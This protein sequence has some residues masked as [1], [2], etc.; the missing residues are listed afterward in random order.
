[1]TETPK[2]DP[3]RSAAIRHL[4]I[5]N[6]EAEPKRR[7]SHLRALLAGL[8]ITGVVASGSTAL[9]LN[10][11]SLFGAPAPSTGVEV[12]TPPTPTASVTTPPAQETES[13]ARISVATAP[14]VPQDIATQPTGPTWSLQPPGLGEPGKLVGSIDISEDYALISVAPE[15]GADLTSESLPASTSSLSVTLVNTRT[16]D[17]V[18]SRE[19]HW[20]LEAGVSSADARALV[21]GTSGRVLVVTT[22]SENGPREV[23]DLSTGTAVAAFQPAEPGETLKKV[24]VV[25]GDS[26]DVYATLAQRD[27][28]GDV[29]PYSLVKRFDPANT[30]DAQWVTRIDA[31]GVNV[32]DS[33]NDIGYAKVTYYAGDPQQ[34]GNGVLDLATGAFV[35]RPEPFEY[36]PF[37]GYTIRSNPD[38]AGGSSTL[39]GLDDDGNTLWT[40]TETGLAQ[41]DEVLTSAAIPGSPRWSTVGTGQFVVVSANGVALVDGLTGSTIWQAALADWKLEYPSV[42]L[43][44]EAQGDVLTVTNFGGSPSS[45]VDLT[46]GAWMGFSPWDISYETSGAEY[47]YRSIDGQVSAIDKISGEVIWTTDLAADSLFFAGGRL[48]ATEGN[49]LRSVG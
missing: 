5:E 34:S 27:D 47:A 32:G 9:A 24:S 15:H 40:R 28:Q 3:Q 49:T 33:G 48:V 43:R 19:W 18:W 22:G 7:T 14:I 6:V 30:T 8:I 46:T 10:R 45:L 16:G 23:L 31:A 12:S 39:T 1:M 44:F 2:F 29:L 21:L 26:G 25:P 35:A 41:V 20:D 36:Y 13:P 4:L 11:D 38:E 42:P 37:T 17:Q